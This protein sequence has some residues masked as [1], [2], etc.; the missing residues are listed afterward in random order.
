M[1]TLYPGCLIERRY[2]GFEKSAISVMKNLDIEFSQINDFT[3]CPDPVWVRS[4]D[5]EIWLKMG[6]RNIAITEKEGNSLVTLCNGCF[7]TLNTVN[8]ILKND[9]K[10]RTLVNQTFSEE[11]ITVEGKIDV[12]HLLYFL[13][14]EIGIDR[15]KEKVKTPLEGLKLAPHPGCHF[16]RPSEFAETDDPLNPQI[17]D[18]M[19]KVLGAEVLEYQDKTECC[20][21]PV[22]VSDREIS[23]SIA[24]NKLDKLLETDGV[25]VIC[26]SCFMQFENAQILG[27]RENKIPVFYY[28]EL[29]ALAM[30]EKP[31]NLGL[32]FHRVNV[33][34]VLKN[35]ERVP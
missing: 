29:L 34:D 30:G 35:K 27:K 32:N 33:L 5:A 3:C 15:I 12:Y 13:Y 17:L 1:I 7:E 6:S 19:I 11:G 9:E 23:L 18:E 25:V 22:F 24:N 8:K 4:Y 20:G 16:S 26:P 31:E 21:L 14:K 2:P 10:K 28:F